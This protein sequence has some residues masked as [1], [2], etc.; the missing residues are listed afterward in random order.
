MIVTLLRHLDRAKFRLAL[1][2]V[3]AR[4]AVFLS[5]VPEDVEFIDLGCRRVR[6]ALLKIF[7]LVWRMRPAVVFS[8]LGHLNIAIAL[9]RPFLP[10]KPRYVAR[11]TMVISQGMENSRHRGI[12]RWAYRRFYKKHDLGVCQSEDMFRDFVDNFGLPSRQAV[13][14]RN[15]VDV[16]HI[17]EMAKEPL[18]SYGDTADAGSVRLIAVGRMIDVKGFDLLVEALALLG[19]ERVHLTILGEGALRGKLEKQTIDLGLVG[20]VLF[21]GFQ[22]NPYAWI[23]RAD[24]LVLSSRHEAFPNVALEAL[25]CGTPVI[26][27]PAPGGTRE[28]L[29]GVPGCVMAE[30]VSAQELANAIGK[31]MSGQRVRVPEDATALYRVEKIVAEYEKLLA[32]HPG[33]P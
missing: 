30:A 2:V 5:D 8:T 25:A 24:A 19:D 17:Q 27:T 20:R 21:P 1:A 6:H 22:V 14:I 28:M 7:S 33:T 9:L 23:A 12:W 29:A 15:P 11:E 10:R 4:M 26:A 32:T 18:P 31:W 16:A 3:D 13:V